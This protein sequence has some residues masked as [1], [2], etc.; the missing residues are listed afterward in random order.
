MLRITVASLYLPY[1]GVPHGGGQDL[2][3]LIRFLGRQHRVRLASFVDAKQAQHAGSI[4]P[5]VA[6]LALVQPAVS[7]RQK[8]TRALVAL[9]N[10]RPRTLGRRAAAELRAFLQAAPADVLYCAW[11]EMGAYLADGP[12]GALRVLD[13]VDVRFIVEEGAPDGLRPGRIARRK[14]QELAYCRQ[15]DLVVTRSARDLAVLR[16]HLPGLAG[17]VL[18]PIAHVADFATIEPAASQ[19]GRVLFV[20]AMD[21]QRNQQAARWLVDAIWPQIRAACPGATLH[22]VGADPPPAIRALGERPGVRVSGWVDDLRAEVAAARVVVAPMNS[23]A[24]ALN[25]VLD[26]LAA[27]RPVV[28]TPPANAGIGAPAA[29]L[30]QAASAGA[31]ARAV[32]RLLQDGGA[33]ARQAEAGRAFIRE[34]F[35]WDHAAGRLEERLLAACARRAR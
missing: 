1:P 31:F 9:R 26:G 34:R 24:G 17:T 21:R 2:F 27:G 16:R 29:A 3:H 25:K 19:P 10:G 14:A 8:A 22:I 28:A 15:A 23:E 7:W 4:L 12:P 6:E 32:L 35:D 20:G 33:W 13:E 11:T 30:S 5:Y 18:P